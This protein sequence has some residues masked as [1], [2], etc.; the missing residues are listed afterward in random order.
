MQE[1]DS[2]ILIIAA[3][4]L[5]IFSY[6]FNLASQ[7]TGI[8][9]VLLLLTSG[10]IVREILVYE[11]ISVVIP[12]R[13]VELFGILGLIM[14]VLEAGLDLEVSR[15]K[16]KL[17]RNAFFSALFILVVSTIACSAWLYYYLNEN[18]LHCFIY[19]IPLSIVSSAIVIPSIAHLQETKKEF[20]VYETSF[21]DI[22]GILLFNYMIA[23]N[24]LKVGNIVLFFGSL[25]LAIILSIILSLLIL[26]VLTRITTKVRLFL[27]FAVLIF[28]Y[29]GGKLLHFPSLLI[30][31]L[32]GLIVSNWHIPIFHRVHKWISFKQVNEVSSMLHSLA[33]ESSFLIRTFF[34]FIFGLTI[35]IRLLADVEVVLSGTAIVLALLVIRF[36]Y[37][38]FFLHSHIF[39]E[40]FFMP[41]GLITILLFYSIPQ[42]YKLSQF[43]EG[44]LFF[45]ILATSII[46][47]IGSMAYGKPKVQIINDELPLSEIN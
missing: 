6:L 32:F 40:L 30:I 5:V 36:I 7:K 41:R 16:I 14:I 29:A 28:L 38:R 31:L 34:F 47:M 20:L 22:V 13:V 25:T 4:L 2:H 1:I 19:A 23:G 42:I 18:Y 46:M 11:N 10:I 33:A 43:N 35:D 39:P 45:I 8:P 26:F 44:I 3:C 21:S 24:L 17:I 9:S 12:P 37:L 15:N 27:V